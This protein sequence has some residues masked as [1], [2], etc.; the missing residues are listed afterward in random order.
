MTE[1]HDGTEQADLA[2]IRAAQASGSA[3]GC[4]LIPIGVILTT[5]GL[6]GAVK[7]AL[8][9][10]DTGGNAILALPPGL[11]ALIIGWLKG[12]SARRAAHVLANGLQVTGTV[13]GSKATGWFSGGASNKTPQH[14]ITFSFELDGGA[15]SEGHVKLYLKTELVKRRFGPGAAFRLR[16]DPEDHSFVQLD[17][18]TGNRQSASGL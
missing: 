3:L 10:T 5:I 9:D 15:T 13:V 6:F 2:T 1:E 7:L 17:L 16:V 8:G 14:Q 12:K 11:V 18:S 4:L